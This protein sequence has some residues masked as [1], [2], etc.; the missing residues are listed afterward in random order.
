M[1]N[2]YVIDNEALTIISSVNFT[3]NLGCHLAKGADG[4]VILG[5]VGD[6]LF[7]IKNYEM[8]KSEKLQTRMSE[9]LENGSSRYIVRIGLHKFIVNVNGDNIE[10]VMDLC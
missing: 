5:Y 8:L 2:K 1:Q 10:Y 7:K 9:K 6:K 3:D 4:Y